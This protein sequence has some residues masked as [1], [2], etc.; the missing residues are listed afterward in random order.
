MHTIVVGGLC[1]I[2]S[3][4]DDFNVATRVGIPSGYLTYRAHNK[5]SP[6]PPTDALHALTLESRRPHVI[7]TLRIDCSCIAPK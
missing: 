6:P 4:R 1:K 2:Y 7:D 3:F 5:K